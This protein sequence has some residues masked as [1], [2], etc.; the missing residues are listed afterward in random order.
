MEGT[1]ASA[2]G[3]TA[4]VYFIV[5]N[6]DGA[7]DALVGA[8]SS[9]AERVSIRAPE[10]VASTT[11]MRAV[12]A[13]PIPAGGE[14]SFEPGGYDVQLRGLGARLHSGSTIELRLEFEHAGSIAVTAGVR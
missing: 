14:V 1:W 5:S 11:V 13:V 4:S 8:S 12:D 7:D 10:E 6:G 2:A 9:L 3:R